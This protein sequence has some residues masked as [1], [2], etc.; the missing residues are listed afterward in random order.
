[1]YVCLF[2][3]S[4]RNSENNYCKNFKFDI[5]HVYHMQMLTKTFYED[6]ANSLCTGTHKKILIHYGFVKVFLVT[7]F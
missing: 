3:V 2:D 1:M 7:A 6:E 5:L 4:G